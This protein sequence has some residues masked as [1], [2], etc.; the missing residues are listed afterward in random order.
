MVTWIGN[1]A[2][3]I[4]ISDHA[5]PSSGTYAWGLES[6]QIWEIDPLLLDSTSSDEAQGESFGFK[7]FIKK[8]DW[9]L[10]GAKI[11]NETDYLNLKKAIGSWEAASTMLYL[12]VTNEW[13]TN[14]HAVMGTYAA[15]TTLSQ[16]TGCLSNLAINHSFPAT[17]LVNIDFKYK[18]T[19]IAVGA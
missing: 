14:N 17:K 18:K 10:V 9:R 2:S 12:S 13:S 5:T 8:V 3:K 19:M 6:V 16:V 15:P 11:T 1:S 4:V 7:P